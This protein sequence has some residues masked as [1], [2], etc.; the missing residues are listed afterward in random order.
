MQVLSA[1]TRALAVV[2]HADL[3]LAPT[4]AA[5]GACQG[6]TVDR[7]LKTNR[8][9]NTIDTLEDFELTR[10]C[11]T[12]GSSRLVC[13]DEKSMWGRKL[14][15]HA[16]ERLTELSTTN[17]FSNAT[18][19]SRPTV[20]F[21]R[22]PVVLMFGDF[23]QLPPVL[24]QP[25]YDIGQQD[26]KNSKSPAAMSGELAFRG[27]QDT[28]FVLT[29]Q[30]RQREGDTFAEQ[31]RKLRAPSP[32]DDAGAQFWRS[33]KLCHLPQD[34]R[35][36][37]ADMRC[38]HSIVCAAT[39]DEKDTVN[40]RHIEALTDI[41]LGMAT[42]VGRHGGLL[43][44]KKLGMM[45][46]IPLACYLAVGM[47]VKL[48][49]N[50]WPEVHINN[51]SRGVVRDI[52]YPPDPANS[53]PEAPRFTGYDPGVTSR[54]PVVVVEFPDSTGPPLVGDEEDRRHWV[55]IPAVERICDCK[56]CTRTGLPLVVSMGN[57]VHSLQGVTAGPGRSIKHIEILWKRAGES[58]CPGQFYVAVS[59]AKEAA[60]LAFHGETK[61]DDESLSAIGT[62]ADWKKRHSKHIE[63][64][65]KAEDHRTAR[66]AETDR[67]SRH[68]FASR[69]DFLHKIKCVNATSRRVMELRKTQ[70]R[71][72]QRQR[73]T[74]ISGFETQ[75]QPY[76]E[77]SDGDGNEYFSFSELAE[78]CLQHWQNSLDLQYSDVEEREVPV[79]VA[80]ATNRTASTS[81][82]GS[83][84]SSSRSRSRSCS[85]SRRRSRR[86]LV[87]GQKE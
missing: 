86:R 57:T 17:T 41:V 40:Q 28:C 52:L 8:S 72:R 31:V 64:S 6:S 34:E 62:S 14:L 83:G 36:A 7:V 59:R 42:C 85:R 12:L 56:N 16:H 65:K 5:A 32:P 29:Q 71:Q 37:F 61:L 45:K 18:T 66:M 75:A 87:V 33:R 76:A 2:D 46:N 9:A 27:L 84:S 43:T 81:S 44:H 4:G 21:G 39:N 15:G 47:A 50:L 26:V 67:D 63:L 68:P 1:C 60:S 80:A 25:L 82:S 53:G 73:A 23:M 10:L 22:R 77:A 69:L 70:R 38:P 54:M 49:V 55:P 51:G 3:R 58:K 13:L 74:S 79:A 11:S 24:D 30:M 35:S 20:D 48:T 78:A 19:T